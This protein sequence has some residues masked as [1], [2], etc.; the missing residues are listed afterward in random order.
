VVVVA[1]WNFPIAIP[2][3]GVAAALA[4]GNTV[5]LTPASDTVLVAHLLCECWSMQV[6]CRQLGQVI[7]TKQNPV[8]P[9]L[10]VC[11]YLP[12][13]HRSPE[14]IKPQ[15]MGLLLI[16]GFRLGEDG[17]EVSERLVVLPMPATP[18]G[19]RHL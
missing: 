13:L 12:S 8:D 18:G 2:C 10:T 11:L 3:G 1:P 17:H 7:R 6:P 15:R 19:R 14:K 4:A 9:R 16:I 5:I